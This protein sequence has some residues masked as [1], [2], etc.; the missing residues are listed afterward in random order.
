MGRNRWLVVTI[1][2]VL[3]VLLSGAKDLQAQSFPERPTG[4]VNDYAG[5]LNAGERQ[6][7]ERRLTT[8]RDTT[9]NVIVVSTIDNLQG[10]DIETFASKMFN[11][12]KM[13]E[14]DRRNGV[15]LLISRDDRQMRI[16]VG[17][18]L[19]GVIPDIAAGRIIR[20]ILTPAFQQGRVYDGLIRATDTMM[21]LAAGEFTAVDTPG[22]SGSSGRSDEDMES[23]LFLLLMIAYIAI[24]IIVSSRRRRGHSLGRGGIVILPGFGMGG[25]GGSG[26]FGGGGFGGFGGGGGFGSGGGG[27]SGRW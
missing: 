9:S 22:P 4:F 14:G 18:G 25:F 2:L 17:Y 23:V 16:E 1:N 20:D 11:D 8:Y 26:G 15:L 27:A 13:W 6:N 12:W 24:Q 19:E 7:L 3:A 10:V 5:M 21:S